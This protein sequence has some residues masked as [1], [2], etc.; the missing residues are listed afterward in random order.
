MSIFRAL[1][2]TCDGTFRGNPCP[3][4][5]IGPA[6]LTNERAL[7]LAAAQGWSRV[8]GADYCRGCTER[9]AKAAKQARAA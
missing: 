9:R 5:E 4:E 7:A 1:T 6:K 2:I 3:R 8:H